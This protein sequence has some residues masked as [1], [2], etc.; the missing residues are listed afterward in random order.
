[1]SKPKHP[2]LQGSGDQV[3]IIDNIATKLIALIEAGNV[4]TLGVVDQEM[5]MIY[6]VN[7]QI[8]YNLVGDPIKIIGNM[9]DCKGEFT[10]VRI[11]ISALCVFTSIK[12]KEDH[13][14]PAVLSEILD[15]KL[16]DGTDWH[17]HQDKDTLA[18]VVC[19]IWILFYHGDP[20]AYGKLD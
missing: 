7:P 16:L 6:L 8:H 10:Q 19:P 14:L 5:N 11:T 13:N 4:F 18:V 15:P 9:S 17:N 12:K 20:L 1:M 2:E 3:I